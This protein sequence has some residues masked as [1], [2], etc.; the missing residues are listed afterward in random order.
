MMGTRPPIRNSGNNVATIV[1]HS[2]SSG[3]HRRPHLCV[4][5]MGICAQTYETVTG[6]SHRVPPKERQ[7]CTHR[8]LGDKVSLGCGSRQTFRPGQRKPQQRLS[9]NGIEPHGGD[10][11]LDVHFVWAAFALFRL[12]GFRTRRTV[13]QLKRHV[14][15]SSFRVN[16]FAHTTFSATV[17]TCEK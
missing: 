11:I 2:R 9:L 10:T 7:P 1:Q 17:K 6:Y 13:G 14:S 12:V 15:C 3:L 16:F 5:D 8:Q 4:A